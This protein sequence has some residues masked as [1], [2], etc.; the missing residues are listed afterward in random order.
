MVD[1]AFIEEPLPP[2]VEEIV[3]DVVT[4]AF[5]LGDSVHEECNDGSGEG[6]GASLPDYGVTSAKEIE[7]QE[8][9]DYFDPTMLEEAFQELYEGSESTKLAATILLIYS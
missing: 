8:N 1:N 9:S 6:D 7:G 2:H 5:D 4:R 3:H